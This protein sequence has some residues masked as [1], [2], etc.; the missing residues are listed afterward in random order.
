MGRPMPHIAGTASGLMGTTQT[1]FG[2]CGTLASALLYRGDASSTA[3]IVLVGA[4]IIIAGYL[5]LRHH[6]RTA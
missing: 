6:L 1:L 2:T 3:L 4:L 5:A